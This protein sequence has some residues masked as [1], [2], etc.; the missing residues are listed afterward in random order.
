MVLAPD[1]RGFALRPSQRLFGKTLL[2][3]VNE[4]QRRDGNTL[5]CAG[6]AG[7]LVLGNL[8]LP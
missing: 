3:P 5:N 8:V 1:P 4:A 7:P 6:R 2:W